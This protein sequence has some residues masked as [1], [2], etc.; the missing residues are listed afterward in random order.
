[1]SRDIRTNILPKFT[2]KICTQVSLSYSEVLW[3]WSG[4]LAVSLAVTKE[5]A[6]WSGTAY[7]HIELTVESPASENETTAQKSTI[8]LLLKANV[9]ATPP[10]TYVGNESN[11]F[12]QRFS[13]KSN[14]YFAENVFYGINITI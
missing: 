14:F 1:M 13:F 9:I 3:P 10:R 7:G 6:S 4:W 8:K 12:Y 2:T 11:I 5:A